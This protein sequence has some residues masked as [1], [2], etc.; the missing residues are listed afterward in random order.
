MITVT[1]RR[2]EE[3]QVS[4]EPGYYA[5][6]DYFYYLNHFG[7]LMVVSDRAITGYA[8]DDDYRDRQLVRLNDYNRITEAEF[9]FQYDQTRAKQN[10]FLTR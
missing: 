10:S 6:C 3:V 2:E 4:V 5:H 8:A 7:E 1:V 9:L